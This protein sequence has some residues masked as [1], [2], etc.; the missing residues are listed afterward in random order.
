MKKLEELIIKDG[1]SRR[2]PLSEITE[3]VK[4]EMDVNVSKRT[5]RRAIKKTGLKNHIAVVK[6]FISDKNAAAR[7]K[8]CQE[9]LHW[10]SRDWMKVCWSDESAVEVRGTG[11]RV[12]RVWRMKGERFN[13]DCIAPS[14][15][16]GRQSVMMWG[17]FIGN[18]LGPLVLCP[19]GK[20]NAVKYCKVLEENFLGFW[21]AL[22]KDAVFMEDG[23]SIHRAKYSKA[24]RAENNINSLEWPAQSPDLNPIEN[25]WQQLKIAVEKRGP[26]TK[27]ELLVA[28]Q[29]EWKKFGDN[30][31]V[32]KNLVKSMRT[33][34]RGVIEAKGK[35]TKY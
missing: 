25:L 16:S 26:R 31:K 9:R 14:F 20:M 1:D 8:W 3:S 19:E 33:R 10:T 30:K 5:I 6:P 35:H 23:A 7:V 24:W 27:E 28:L 17:C 29:E 11:T 32:L 12:T 18:K 15:K 4:I 13:Q 2:Q 21:N 22:D 34:V